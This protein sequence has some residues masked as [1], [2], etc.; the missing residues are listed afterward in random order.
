MAKQKKDLHYSI[1]HTIER[2]EERY[3]LKISEEDYYA[4]CQLAQ[5]GQ[6]IA[7]EL[8]MGQK[9][10]DVFW[11]E[12]KIRIVWDYLNSRIRTVLRNSNE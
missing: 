10:I 7:N 3:Q 4:L 5:S 2:L 8:D 11:K 12:Q 9:I 1:K 6:I